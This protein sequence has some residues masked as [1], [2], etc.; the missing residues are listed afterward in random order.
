MKLSLHEFLFVKATA[1]FS[2]TFYFCAFYKLFAND[3]KSAAV[4]GLE[5]S[6]IKI[7]CSSCIADTM[8]LSTFP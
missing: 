4:S 2:I 5:S 7:A 8:F 6:F 1:P 3:F